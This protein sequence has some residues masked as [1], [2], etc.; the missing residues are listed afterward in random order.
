M[1]CKTDCEYLRIDDNEFEDGEFE[2][3]YVCIR[4][5][6]SQILSIDEDPNKNNQCD[7]IG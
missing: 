1:K 4:W 3:V 5:H 7:V 6:I 2:T